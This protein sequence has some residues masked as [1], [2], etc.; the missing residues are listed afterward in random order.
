M[1]A[2]R[3]ILNG[4]EHVVAG[5]TGRGV[6][7]AIVFQA[8]RAEECELALNIGALEELQDGSKQDLSWPR[9]DL[10]LGDEIVIRIVAV[11]ECSPPASVALRNQELERQ[12]KEDYLKQLQRELKKQTEG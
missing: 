10:K 7:S 9:T 12:Q 2:F 3:V 1:K 4:K 11:E 8:N 6:I 5:I